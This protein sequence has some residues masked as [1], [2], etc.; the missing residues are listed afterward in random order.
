MTDIFD[1]ATERE[2]M[3][4]ERAIAAARSSASALPATGRCHWCDASV[5]GE[6]HFCDAECRADFERGEAAM[7]R[8]G[9]AR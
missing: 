1:Q 9:W 6:A 3:E 4:R 2:E 5:E 7:R 8:G